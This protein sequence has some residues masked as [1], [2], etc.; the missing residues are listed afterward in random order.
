METIEIQDPDDALLEHFG[1]KG[2]KW[3]VRQG[4]S[5]TGI[6]RARGA[7]ID[8]NDRYIRRL[9]DAQKG[10]GRISDRIEMRLAKIQMGESAVKR[11]ANL[12]IA[13]LRDQNK[14]LKSGKAT[15]RDKLNILM[16]TTPL[17][18]VLSNRPKK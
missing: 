6:S 7:K 13:E 16:T 17:E 2:M 15:V 10:K 11:H 12:Q 18:L 8:A 5:K 1:R 14:R 9:Q 3:G 4:S